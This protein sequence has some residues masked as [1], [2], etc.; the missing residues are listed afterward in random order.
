MIDRA[1]SAIGDGGRDSSSGMRVSS[2][3]A[4]ALEVSPGEYVS[5]FH[6]FAP[7]PL[8]KNAKTGRDFPTWED[9][10]AL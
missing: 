2:D 5:Q 6:P 10:V 9:V 7:V 8:S 4:F 1:R 3:K